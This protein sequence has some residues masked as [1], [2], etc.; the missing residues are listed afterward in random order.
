MENA[1][2]AVYFVI[3]KEVGIKNK[4]FAVFCGTGNNGGDG[5]VVARKIHSNGGE[6]KVFLLDD[7]TKFKGIA[8]RNFEIVS[9]MPI[10][11]SKISSNES[12][13]AAIH[14]SDAIVDAIFGTGLIR[15]VSGIYK[16]VI[17]VINESKKA[18]FSVDIPSSYIGYTFHFL[19]MPE[20]FGII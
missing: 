18:V 1:G 14:N 3:L 9:K 4:S 12:I 2:Q 16:D 7:E 17:Q 13:R 8:K 19:F 5:L 10:E 6:A 20:M 11:I 15:E